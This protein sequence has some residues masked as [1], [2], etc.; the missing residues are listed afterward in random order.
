MTMMGA[1]CGPILEEVN[2]TMEHLMLIVHG[3]NQP[4]N[5]KVKLGE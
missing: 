1:V 2:I 4:V 3:I 5:V